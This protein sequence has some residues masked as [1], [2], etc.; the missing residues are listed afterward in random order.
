MCIHRARYY[1]WVGW[2]GNPMRVKSASL[3]SLIPAAISRSRAAHLIARASPCPPPPR[4][5]GRRAHG[6]AAAPSSP[7]DAAARMVD[8]AKAML[9]QPYRYGGAAPGGFDCS[10]L[11]IFAAQSAGVVLPRTAGEQLRAGVRIDRSGAR[12]GRSRVH[13]SRPQGASRRHRDRRRPIHPRARGGRT[14]A[15]RFSRRRALFRGLHR[16]AACDRRAVRTRLLDPDSLYSRPAPRPRARHPALNNFS[17]E[18][19]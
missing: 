1:R 11:V 12:A 19:V 16:R 13:A 15:H 5:P 14:R 10:G 17:E 8:A 18:L 3:A 7:V 6:G 2:A 4:A 9:G